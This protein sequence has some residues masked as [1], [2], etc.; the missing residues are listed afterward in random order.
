MSARLGIR[1]TMSLWIRTSKETSPR[2]ATGLVIAQ[3][4]T[5][6]LATCR[7]VASG[8]AQN[9]GSA[10]W[11]INPT[12]RTK[13]LRSSAGFASADESSSHELQTSS[14]RTREQKRETMST[15]VLYRIETARDEM[16]PAEYLGMLRQAA[17]DERYCQQVSN[18]C[19]CHDCENVRLADSARARWTES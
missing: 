5:T 1:A 14:R 3:F 19:Y 6:R 17:D 8:T 9:G 18:T 16:S 11:R 4:A 15:S 12:D 10:T 2:R 13:R 7:V